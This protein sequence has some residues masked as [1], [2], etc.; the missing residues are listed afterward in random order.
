MKIIAALVIALDTIFMAL[1]GVHEDNHNSKFRKDYPWLYKNLSFYG[2]KVSDA[3]HDL[4]Y[5]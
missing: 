4:T 2:L 5:D 3:N 1:V